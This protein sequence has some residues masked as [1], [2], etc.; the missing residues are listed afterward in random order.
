MIV[1]GVLGLLAFVAAGLTVSDG[2][3]IPAAVAALGGLALLGYGVRLIIEVRR[4]PRN[5]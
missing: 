1:F 5:S 2:Y 3:P 4:E